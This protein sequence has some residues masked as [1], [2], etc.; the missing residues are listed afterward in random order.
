MGTMVYGFFFCHVSDKV[1]ADQYRDGSFRRSFFSGQ[2]HSRPA[3]ATDSKV[4]S[5]R[6]VVEFMRAEVSSVDNLCDIATGMSG[7]AFQP[8]TSASTLSTLAKHLV[9]GIVLGTPWRAVNA[10]TGVACPAWAKTP[11]SLCSFAVCACCTGHDSDRSFGTLWSLSWLPGTHPI[12]SVCRA[13][14]NTSLCP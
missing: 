1:Q 7:R 4:D 6:D 3:S 11:A 10:V 5:A 2:R 14:L 8:G 12:C 9:T 13:S